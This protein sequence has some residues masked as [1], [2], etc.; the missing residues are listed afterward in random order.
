MEEVRKALS[1]ISCGRSQYPKEL[2]ALKEGFWGRS[3]M[4]GTG[5]GSAGARGGGTG[6]YSKIKV[7]TNLRWEVGAVASFNPFDRNLG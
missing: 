1:S 6:T 2:G 4:E 7:A 3:H 5:S